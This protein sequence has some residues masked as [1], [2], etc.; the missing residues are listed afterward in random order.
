[1]ISTISLLLLLLIML[2]LMTDSQSNIQVTDQQQIEQADS[3]EALIDWAVHIRRYAFY[4][5]NVVVNNAQLSALA[6]LAQRAIPAISAKALINNNKGHFSLSYRLTHFGLPRYINLELTLVAA[7]K[8]QLTQVKL[9]SFN[10]PSDLA[11]NTVLKAVNW[12]VGGDLVEQLNQRIINVDV[13]NQ[14]LNISLLPINDLLAQAKSIQRD[15]S[16]EEISFQNDIMYYLKV[17]KLIDIASEAE[18]NTDVSAAHYITP[19]FAEVSARAIDGEHQVQNKAAIIALATFSGSRHFGRI[20]GNL[21]PKWI[22]ANQAQHRLI[23][24]GRRDLYLHFIFSAAIEVLAQKGI[25]IAIGEFK[26]LLDRGDNGSGFSFADLAADMT[27]I[28]LAQQAMSEEAKYVSQG[29]ASSSSEKHFFPAIFDLPEGLYKS[30]FGEK[31]GQID[32]PIYQ[33]Y[34]LTIHQRIQQLPLFNSL[35]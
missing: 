9:G 16:D 25:S 7:D 13:A 35:N 32:S 20:V 12:Y 11:F 2:V 23:L 1:M 19:L 17:L 6:G 4:Q 28:T 34:R 29:L 30:E 3:L 31:I 10:L 22:S 8:I 21:D 15:L 5:Q 33:Q 18:L 24:A 26:E 14:A 27:G